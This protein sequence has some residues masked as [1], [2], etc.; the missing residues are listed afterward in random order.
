VITN[1]ANAQDS[2][3]GNFVVLLVNDIVGTIPAQQVGEMKAF[4]LS[5][6]QLYGV[7]SPMMALCDAV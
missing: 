4:Y 7:S 6:L 5:I 3:A 1:V 2:L